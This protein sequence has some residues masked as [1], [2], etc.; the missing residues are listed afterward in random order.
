VSYLVPQQ[1]QSFNSSIRRFEPAYWD[2]DFNLECSATIITTSANA[3]RL[4]GL[5]RSNKC[6]VGAFFRSKDRYGHPLYSYE[7]KADWTNC[8]LAF[9]LTYS[10]C[11]V[12]NDLVRPLVM[13]ATDMSGQ[14]WYIHLKNF[15]TAG[16]PS[17]TSGSFSIN[18][19]TAKAGLSATDTVPW[20]F[21]DNIYIGFANTSYDKF[22]ALAPIT[23]TA[24]Q[25]DMTNISVTG[26]NVNIGFNTTA[27]TAHGLRMADGYA[28]SYPMT[29]ERIVNQLVKLGYR[30]QVVMYVGFTQFTS[31]TWNGGLGR[32]QIDTAKPKVNVPT[33]QWFTDYCT[34]LATNS[35]GMTMSVSFEIL[36][37]LCPDAWVQKDYAGAAGK[38]GWNP[39]SNFVSPSSTP[40]M[41]YLK[42]VA[43]AFVGLG[44]AAG[45]TTKYQ[46]GEPWWWPGGYDN[47]GPCFYDANVVAEYL[48]ATGQPVPTPY[49][50]TIYSDYSSAPQTAYLTWLQGKLGSATLSL[51]TA[52]QT[53]Y[54]GTQ[55]GVLFY[56]PTITN[57]IAPM[58]KL[59]DFPATAW[60]SPAWDFIQVEDY[61]VI[62]FGNFVQQRLDLDVPIKDLGYPLAKC[63]YFSGFNLLDATTFIWDKIDYAIWQAI[64]L[65]GYPEALVWARPQVCRDGW[66]YNTDKYASYAAAVAAPSYPVFPPI[67]ALGWGVHRT[68]SF[69]NLISD[70]VSGK[71]VRSPRAVYPRWEFDLTYEAL[72]SKNP[73][74]YQ[75]MLSFFQSMAGKDGRFWFTDPENNTAT[76]QFIGTGDGFR[77]TWALV[78]SVGSI[79]EEPIG[80]VNA[81][82][83]VRINGVVQ[84]GSTYSVW[85]NDRWPSIKFNTPPANAATITATFSYYFLC[86]FANDNMNFEEF[87]GNYHRLRSCKFITVKP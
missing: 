25:A 48:S 54:P 30:G 72:F 58:L 55:C 65:K 49:L 35:M 21:I 52:V 4:K 43:V 26:T 77:T 75:Q 67:N 27:Q 85:Y 53:A 8:V 40:G 62:E 11:P 50:Q 12:I 24:M 46:V 57:P 29:P 10:G 14:Q 18:T 9:D 68:P 71:E 81:L 1:P 36:G 59:V 76:A 79:Y 38:T 83:E 44:V 13:V 15:M 42:D 74:T 73:N 7:Q 80:G 3:W 61:E 66:V 17:S 37:T 28:D 22:A 39:A 86:R 60:A 16:S 20:N 64:V 2:I 41:Q 69:N 56:T 23:E 19:N 6:L 5:F 34:R 82:T 63:Q 70:H 87:M 45:A 51:K 31:V 84:S 33:Q 47:N 78:R 32:F